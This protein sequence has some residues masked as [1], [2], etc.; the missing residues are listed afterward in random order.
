[1]SYASLFDDVSASRKTSR[2]ALGSGLSEEQQTA[3]VARFDESA[4][5]CAGA[6]AGKTRLLVERV[7]ALLRSGANPKRIAVV[8]FTR[9]AAGEIKERVANR[10]GDKARVPVCGTVHALALSVLTR[11]KQVLSLA[12]EQQESACVA[13]LTALLPDEFQ[14]LSPKELLLLVHRAREQEEYHTLE[15]L[16]ALAYEE[17]LAEASLQDFTTLLSL[18]S[19]KEADLF[20]HVLVDEA[21]DL[22]ALQLKFL[23]SI[24][25]RARFWF[26]GDP[27]QAIYSFRGAHAS[28]MHSL[29]EQCAGF[30]VLSVNYR[31]A[32][33][34]VAHANNVIKFNKERFPVSW[35]A[36]R[37]EE[38][39]VLVE[40][41]DH[42][43]HELAAAIR[44]AE[45]APKQR[46]VLAR[47]QA[48]VSVLKEQGLPAM[49]VHESKGLEWPEVLIMGCEAAMFPHPLATRDEER[50]LFY[51]AMTRARDQLLMTY[52]ANRSH[53]NP[54]LKTRHPSPFLF[55]TQA[56]QAKS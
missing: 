14:D 23:R 28:M 49:T 29:R 19:E 43:E 33:S 46:C 32:T 34:I 22:S 10:I 11:R 41:F 55:E 39:S 24:G 47:T 40:A 18:A 12:S 16:V 54:L 8:T 2:G 38:G 17:K 48:L 36:A 30:Y 45:K 31:S 50:R 44:W 35:S 5:I 15:G 42:G 20:D 9:K 7:S 27:D 51:V 56:L 13:Q 1:M 26:I 4:V 6:G 21:Q 25:P 37:H 53:K 52:A 3:L